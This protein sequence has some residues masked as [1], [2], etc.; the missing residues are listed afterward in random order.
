MTDEE[1]LEKLRD[2]AERKG[3]FEKAKAMHKSLH[4]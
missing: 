3:L 4:R 2:K 1:K